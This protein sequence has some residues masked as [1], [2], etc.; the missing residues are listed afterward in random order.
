MNTTQM[1]SEPSIKTTLSPV[2]AVIYALLTC[3]CSVLCVLSLQ[4]DADTAPLSF[5][6]PVFLF[7]AGYF[8]SALSAHGQKILFTASV[9]VSLAG[10]YFL[11]LD[12]FRS[13]VPL[14]AFAVGIFLS[15]ACK[16]RK[17]TQS[18]VICITIAIYAVFILLSA[19]VLCYQKYG[20][21]TSDTLY[22]IYDSFCNILMKG[23]EQLLLNMKAE[24]GADAAYEA[25]IKDY[26]T[27]LKLLRETLK[28]TIYFI[29][30]A[31][32]YICTLGAFITFKGSE[33]HR[34]M[35][36]LPNMLGEF[37][38]SVVTAFVYIIIYFVS[39]FTDPTSPLGLTLNTVST[40]PGLAL[41]L[42][43][44]I[45]IYRAI[46]KHPK[47]HIYTIGLVLILLMFTSMAQSVLSL[48]GAYK[49]VQ[50]YFKEK[51]LHNGNN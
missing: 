29:P 10:A 4:T 28:L 31:F 23:P 47:A 19:A 24:F 1:N 30:S 49:S 48:V 37:S 18:G 33:R 50:A 17:H 25:V 41:A 14:G 34:R 36:G 35:Q 27:T 6:S 16:S 15:S 11:S 13:L 42:Y 9:C 45:Y 46:K 12:I 39:I 38:V 7:C 43:G 2:G 8:A 51:K 26:E 20:E 44:L 21:L 3:V 22:R 5:L 32:L 40:V